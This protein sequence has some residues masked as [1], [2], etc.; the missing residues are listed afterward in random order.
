MILSLSTT[1]TAVYPL[2]L[3]VQ[4][5]YAIK[6]SYPDTLFMYTVLLLLLLLLV[7]AAVVVEVANAEATT[8]CL[9]LCHQKHSVNST[10]DRKSRVHKFSAS[11]GASHTPR[12]RKGD[13]RDVQQVPYSERSNIRHH[14][15]KCRR[16]G[17][18][19]SMIC[20]PLA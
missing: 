16:S 15:T 12:L 19:V 20:A 3:L 17:D 6:L 9:N 10:E 7:A 5:L 13:K 2:S 4:V 11:L 14:H 8:L 1:H 18:L